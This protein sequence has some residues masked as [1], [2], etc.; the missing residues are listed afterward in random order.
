MVPSSLANAPSQVN[1]YNGKR[2]VTSL[3]PTLSAKVTDPHGSGTRAQFELT[4][5]PGYADTTYS[6]T[7]TSSSVS[8]ARRPR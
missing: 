6:Y 5:D 4:A 2:Y 7:G 8:S 1:A 3:T